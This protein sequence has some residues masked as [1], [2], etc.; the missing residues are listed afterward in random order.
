MEK[1]E[2]EELIKLE[3]EIKNMPEGA[4]RAICWIIDNLDFVI[5]MCKDSD[6]TDEELDKHKRIAWEKKDYMAF[7]LLCITK[8]CKKDFQG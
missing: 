3:K 8:I 5:D 6:I 7:F 2:N 4:Q 1:N